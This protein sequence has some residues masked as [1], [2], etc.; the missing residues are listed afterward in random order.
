MRLPI[1]TSSPIRQEVPMAPSGFRV[2]SLLALML[3]FPVLLIL[4]VAVAVAG[5]GQQTQPQARTQQVLSF[6]PGAYGVA[7][8]STTVY[9]SIYRSQTA[10]QPVYAVPVGGGRASDIGIRNMNG[11]LAL[12]EQRLYWSDGSSLLA[13]Q[14]VN[15]LGSTVLL[16]ASQP[17]VMDIA[18]DDAN[19]YWGTSAVGSSPGHIRKVSKSGGTPLVDAGAAPDG[20]TPVDASAALDAGT[21]PDG[22]APTELG[23]A[24]SPHD[25]AVDAT[26]VYWVEQGG[27]NLNPTW[28]VQSSFGLM[29]APIT[30]GPPVQLAVADSNI[31][32]GLALDDDNAYFMDGGGSL[33]SVPKSGGPTHLM[34]SDL[35]N[36]IVDGLASDGTNLYI[37]ADAKVVKVPLAGGFA[38]V[39]ATNIGDGFGALPTNTLDVT[40][41]AVDATSVYV[42]DRDIVVKVAK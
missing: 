32:T 13:C 37:G 11:A 22:T 39:L 41:I 17:G 16:A 33:F 25:V 21:A 40:S 38:S 35:G 42:A 3:A 7:V 24:N 5:C 34:L 30:G 10:P 20:S 23:L 36:L 29:K 15:C 14:K 8:D 28:P 27:W 6:L 31:P 12:D 1:D 9:V 26:S 4:S 19:V 2:L 18:L